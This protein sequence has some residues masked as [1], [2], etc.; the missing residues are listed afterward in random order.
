MSVGGGSSLFLKAEATAMK[1]ANFEF[2]FLS[3]HELTMF[4]S[5]A[6][7]HNFWDYYK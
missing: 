3:N 1:L 7:K 4:L 5:Q 2:I 6:I